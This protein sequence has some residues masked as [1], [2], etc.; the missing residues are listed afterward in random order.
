MRGRASVGKGEET[1][2]IAKTGRDGFVN[3]DGVVES[4]A[5]ALPQ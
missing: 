5:C 3:K 1:M 4:C 2:A